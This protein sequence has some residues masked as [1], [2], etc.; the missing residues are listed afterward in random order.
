MVVHGVREVEGYIYRCKAYGCV[1]EK[2]GQDGWLYM[3][4]GEGRAGY[5]GVSLGLPSLSPA[6]TSPLTST[7]DSTPA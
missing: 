6:S 5:M 7:Q 1:W 3:R 4:K 2:A